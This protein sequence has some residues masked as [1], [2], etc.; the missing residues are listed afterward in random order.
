MVVIIG[1]FL[2]LWEVV[3]GWIEGSRYV[4]YNGWGNEWYILKSCSIL[5]NVGCIVFYIISYLGFS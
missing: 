3:K 1:E 5:S 2:Y 4:G